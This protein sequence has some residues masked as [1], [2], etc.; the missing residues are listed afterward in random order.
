MRNFLI[1]LLLLV[2][3][4]FTNARADEI[5]SLEIQR[6]GVTLLGRLVVA[7]GAALSDGVLIITHGTFAHKD[8]EL[9][10]NLQRLL[11]E[12]G[13]SSLTHTLSLGI[14]RRSGMYDCALPFMG[15]MEGDDADITAWTK[16]LS[17]QGATKI[18]LM[19]HSR[20][21]VQTAR[22]AADHAADNLKSI[23]MLAPSAGRNYSE[24]LAAYDSRFSGDISKLLGKAEELAA[25][26]AGDQLMDV[27][28]FV[29]CEKTKASAKAIASYYGSNSSRLTKDI[30]TDIKVPVLIVVGTDDDVVGDVAS[31]L[32]SVVDGEGVRLSVIDGKSVV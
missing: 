18:S 20:G 24:H 27:P 1:C 7:E 19:G 6:D 5:R 11:A 13:I 29:Y 31:K 16:W 15:T 8:M 30:I 10:A 3:G 4:F 32:K 21:A 9:I 14:D 22:F 23:V 26:G 2:S 17:D 25:S 28:G 12:R